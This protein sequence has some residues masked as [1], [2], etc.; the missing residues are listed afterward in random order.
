[1]RISDMN[2]SYFNGGFVGI[3]TST[4]TTQLEVVGNTKISTELRTQYIMLG[5]Q[6][7]K[8]PVVCTGQ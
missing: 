1:M 4:P 3:G 5:G 2:A 8:I 7:L 6:P